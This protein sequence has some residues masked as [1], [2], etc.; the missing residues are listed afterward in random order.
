LL[1]TA[2]QKEDYLYARKLALEV[3]QSDPEHRD[4]QTLCEEIVGK[5]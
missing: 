1:L 5:L 4:I 2:M 3:I